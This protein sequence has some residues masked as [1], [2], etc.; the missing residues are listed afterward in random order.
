M[1]PTPSHN[2][3]SLALRVYAP[4]GWWLMIVAASIF[5]MVGIGGVT[6]LTGSGLSITDWRPVTGAVPPL[7]E[8]DWQ[9]EFEKYQGSPQHR[10]A[11]PDMTV[12]EFKG[13]YWWEWIHRFWGRMIGVL[14]LLPLLAFWAGGRIPA[15]W[16]RKLL[17]IFV[18]GGLQGALGWFMVKSGL[19]DKPSVSPYRLAA[20]LFLAVALFAWVFRLGLEIL[21]G[22]VAT[23]VSSWS[24]KGAAN[25]RLRLHKGLRLFTAL[26]FFQIVYGALAAG[27][28]AAMAYPTFPGLGGSFW[29]PA[30]SWTEPLWRNFFENTAVIAFT[31][32]WL[33]MALFLVGLGLAARIWF[34]APAPSRLPAG[35]LAALLLLQVLLGIG[36]TMAAHGHIPVGMAVM[37]QLNALLI[38]AATLFLLHQTRP[39]T[40]PV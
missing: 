21:R 38:L 10:L 3:Q 15:G 2:P 12:E 35:V 34:R 32:R 24:A 9:V 4:L 8:A 28:K 5:L 18:L 27:T 36:T 40:P 20:H 23:N 33:G 29:P 17:L 1:I 14:F 16:G 22:N 37:H 19:V 26:L 25:S 31:H 13:I 6:R 30:G 39:P 7:N 11:F